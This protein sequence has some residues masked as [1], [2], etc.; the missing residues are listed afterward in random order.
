RQK[1]DIRLSL[2]DTINTQRGWGVLVDPG[3][4]YLCFMLHTDFIS[5]E[6][7]LIRILKC[8]CDLLADLGDPGVDFCVTAAAFIK[9][10]GIFETQAHMPKKQVVGGVRVVDHL[11]LAGYPVFEL[12]HGPEL[13]GN[14]LRRW[15]LG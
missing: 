5:S 7:H 13:G 12:W 9:D 15:G 8:V 10:L 2:T 11:K 14:A 3:F 4:A 6:H 1:P